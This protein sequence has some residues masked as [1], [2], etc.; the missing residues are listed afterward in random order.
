MLRLFEG[1]M[2]RFDD[3]ELGYVADVETDDD[4]MIY[5]IEMESGMPDRHTR[6]M[7]VDLMNFEEC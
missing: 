1:D 4:D 6:G 5:W 2:V 3:G 7:D